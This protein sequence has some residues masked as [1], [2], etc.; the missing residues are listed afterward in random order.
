MDFGGIVSPAAA[1]SRT[2]ST[3]V[4]RRKKA[5]SH[6]PAFSFATASS[7]L[8][9][10]PSCFLAAMSSCAQACRVFEEELLQRRRVEPPVGLRAV[11]QRR[12]EQLRVLGAQPPGLQVVGVH[13]P[14]AAR[15]VAIVGHQLVLTDLTQLEAGFCRVA[16]PLAL[17]V[18]QVLQ[19]AV[20][21]EDRQAGVLERDQ[22]HQ[23]VVGGA[24][25]S[26]LPLL[27]R[28]GHR[29]LVAVMAVGDQQ[30]ALGQLVRDRLMDAGVSDAPDAVGRPLGVGELAPGLAR[31]GWLYRRPGVAGI[32]GEDGGEVVLRRPG[33]TQPV[34]LRPRLGAL[35]RP[36]S[37]A[38]LRQPHPR[39]E[40]TT[41]HLPPIGRRV[42]LGQR[43]D[44]P[45]SVLHE[46]ALLLPAL[47]HPARVLV[48]VAAVGILREIKR[49][50]VVGRPPRELGP[51]RRV[52][53]VI[54]RRD[55]VP[56]RPDLAEVVVERAQW[57]N[58]S[59]D[60][61]P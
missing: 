51:P 45:L 26:Q 29:G 38:V 27:A 56:E 2:S 36:Y 6:S 46:R 61:E 39:Q 28:V 15:R 57:F 18:V 31:S 10:Y 19:Q 21:R 1:T 11:P 20:R 13:V 54:G 30:L 4:G 60:A 22:R 34:L 40:P 35:V 43:P 55:H 7:A 44:R 52:D 50:H 42:V 23:H 48:A 14:E 17:F 5:A 9:V 16:D 58:P 37:L 33:Q 25:G 3:G 47:Q 41:G 53:H 8:G 24:A 59:H 12:L 49:D 32:Q